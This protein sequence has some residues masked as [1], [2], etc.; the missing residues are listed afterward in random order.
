MSILNSINVT[1]EKIM[2]NRIYRTGHIT[3]A[4][5]FKIITILLFPFKSFVE[6]VKAVLTFEG[7]SS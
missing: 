6:L 4:R 2:I 7:F 5:N 3:S 1:I